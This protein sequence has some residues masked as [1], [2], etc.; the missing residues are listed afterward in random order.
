VTLLEVLR[1][2][3][4]RSYQTKV[5]TVVERKSISSGYL[6]A[7]FSA[8]KKFT[9]PRGSEGQESETKIEDKG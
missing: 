3:I 9:C 5:I 6:K 7:K 8:H 4:N 2:V 1:E